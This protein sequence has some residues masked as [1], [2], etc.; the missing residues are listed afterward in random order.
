VDTGQQCARPA[1]TDTIL[2]WLHPSY[3][4]VACSLGQEPRV[5]PTAGAVPTTYPAAALA[6]LRA[7]LGRLLAACRAALP[8]LAALPAEDDSAP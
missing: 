1:C 7:C 3:C 2:T 6:E 4:S 5:L 8:A